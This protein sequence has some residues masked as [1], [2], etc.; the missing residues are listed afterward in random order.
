MQKIITPNGLQILLPKEENL[1][2]PKK[3][4]EGIKITQVGS[5]QSTIFTKCI[6]LLF[7][8]KLL[9]Y[10]KKL[11]SKKCRLR[12]TIELLENNKTSELNLLKDF[13]KG[14][15]SFTIDKKELIPKKEEKGEYSYTIN[16]PESSW[17]TQEQYLSFI[18]PEPL[19]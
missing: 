5:P 8:S 10:Q 18:L 19:E 17:L 6:L 2:V 14:T 12:F 11:F 1:G 13:F 3:I 9:I 15:L 16:L 4:V 7:D